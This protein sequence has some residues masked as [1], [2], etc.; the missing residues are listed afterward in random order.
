MFIQIVLEILGSF[1]DD[2]P[3]LTSVEMHL[4]HLASRNGLPSPRGCAGI[5]AF[6]VVRK[7]LTA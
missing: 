7:F 1:P 6:W 2:M 5:P 3:I 4:L